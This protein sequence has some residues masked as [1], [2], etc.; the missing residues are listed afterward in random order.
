MV[1]AL[2]KRTRTCDS[3]SICALVESV[4]ALIL[5]LSA[6]PELGL[7]EYKTSNVRWPKVAIDYFGQ[8]QEGFLLL[9]RS[10]HPHEYGLGVSANKTSDLGLK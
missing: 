10:D 9:T 2:H 1:I 7:R 4:K 8:R 3:F 5:S 6:K